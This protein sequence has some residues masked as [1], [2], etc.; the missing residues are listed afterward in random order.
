MKPPRRATAADRARL[1][2]ALTGTAR[3][4]TRAFNLLYRLTA[5]KLFGICLRIC[6]E[7]RAAEDV[8]QEVY[9]TVWN[10]A[11]GFD[12]ARG[13]AI[14]WLGSIA[15]NRAIDWR[16]GQ[17]LPPPAP[18]EAADAIPDAQPTAPE[19]MQLDEEAR[20]M[21]DALDRL[22]PR[23]RAAIRSAFFDGLSYAELA[24]REGIALGTMK[25]WIR[26]GLLRLREQLDDA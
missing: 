14:A 4:D 21:L 26:R 6:G 25:S 20:R 12:P 7:R 5:A 18:I 13:G 17:H 10:R 9:L 15:R 3:R 22:D 16:R 11:G 23:A 19:R 1:V 2:T 24:Q 8:L